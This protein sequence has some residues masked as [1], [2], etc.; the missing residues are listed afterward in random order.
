MSFALIEALALAHDAAIVDVGG[1]ASGLA[2]QLLELGF[3]DV[4]VLDISAP[5]LGHARADL[6]H[7][8][9]RVRWIEQDLLSWSP[10]RRYDL[11]HD[12][13]VFHFLVAV[14]DRQR[15]ADLLHS[16]LRPGGKAIIGAFAA[17]GPPS[18]LGPSR[19]SRK[20]DTLAA[21]FGGIFTTLATSREEHHTPSGFIQPFAWVTLERGAL[22]AFAGG[23]PPVWARSDGQNRPQPRIQSLVRS[24][25]S[26]DAKP[27]DVRN[28]RSVRAL[29]R[30]RGCER[31]FTLIETL[32][33]LSI[34]IVLL[35]P[36]VALIT[37]AQNQTAGDALRADTI[38]FASVGLREMGQEL[39]QAY[40]IEVS[41]H[42][43]RA[44]RAPVARR[45]RPA[46]PPACRP[47]T[48][49]TC[50]HA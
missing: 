4:T 9:T 24:R 15:Y 45:A 48:C 30:R 25:V 1:G 31:G 7:D 19:C 29:L 20:A 5:A 49:S 13:A 35:V 12:R 18:V 41:D 10:D 42:L 23:R 21:T 37:T 6:G 3:E 43:A 32:V 17:D 33:S 2:S 44:I 8:A 46:R 39:R 14:S 16:T 26:A 40:E 22:D 50:S 34:A 27:M 11:W 47:A 38:Q 36:T 28:A